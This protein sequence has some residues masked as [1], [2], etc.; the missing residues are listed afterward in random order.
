[1]NSVV[2][3]VVTYNRKE[4]LKE[5]LEAILEQ[6]YR[7]CDVILVDNGSTD[8]TYEYIQKNIESDERIIYYNT[9]SNL[10]GAGGFNYGIKKAFEAGYT[11][12]WLLDDDSIVQSDSLEQLLNAVKELKG[13]FGFLCSNV[14]WIDGSPC[15][16]NIPKIDSVW[17]LDLNTLSKGIIPVKTATFV[18][19]FTTRNNVMKVGLPIKEFFI[20]SDDTNY[21]LRLNKLN[22]CYCV[23]NS[24]IVHKMVTNTSSDIVA[25]KSD[26]IQRYFYSYRNK[27]FNARYEKKVL[28]Y[29]FKL[30]KTTC[31]VILR[32]NHKMKKLYYMY[33]GLFAGLFFNPTIEHVSCKVDNKRD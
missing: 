31:L 19:F 21:C 17:N 25:D 24:I 5:A 12:Y 33:K 18:G 10:G 14:R 15:L 29:S 13:D 30:I 4:L 20:W 8:G 3:I 32:S 7:Q 6:S 1:M 16:M 23:S 11:Y 28:Q 9:H 22:K 2:A 27:L 26:R